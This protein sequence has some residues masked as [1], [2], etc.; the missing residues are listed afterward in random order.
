MLILEFCLPQ[1]YLHF[2]WAGYFLNPPIYRPVKCRSQLL[3]S[4][5]L[6]V[7]QRKDSS[8]MATEGVCK[9]SV[10]IMLTPRSTQAVIT[11]DMSAYSLQVF[12]H[13]IQVMLILADTVSEA[14]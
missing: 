6:S 5:Q 3:K 10:M 9:S 2:Y 12:P 8:D 14:L 4:N 13:T 11:K 1:Y 7:V